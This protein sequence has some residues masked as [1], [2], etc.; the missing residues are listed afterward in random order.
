MKNPLN[1]RHFLRSSTAL[2][3]LPFLESLGF[4]RF[5]SAAV[6][7]AGVP[8]PKRLVFL[9]FGW[10]VTQDSWY[11]KIEQQ[12]CDYTLPAGLEPLAR[13]RADFSVVQGL[14]NKY[15]SN[16]HYGSTFWLTGANEFGQAGQSFHN[17]VS[18]DQVAGEHLGKEAR[19]DSLVLDC[20]AAAA[21]SGHGQ[22]LSLS[23]D[24]RGKPI[25]GPK[26]PVEAF[27][28]L[29]AKDTT[30]LAQ[31]KAML[32]Q[33]RSVLD[34]ALENARE[35][36][37]SLSK[38]DNAK[39]DEYFQGIRDIETRLSRDEKWLGVPRPEAPLKEPKS[40]LAGYEEIRLMYA[41]MAAAL[42]T[43]STR[44]LTY[45]QPV[46]TLLTSLDIRIDAHTMSHYLGKGPEY[47]EA[48]EKRDHAQSALLA[49]LLDQLKA[50]KEPDGSC[51]LDHTTVAFGSNIRT[52]HSLDNCPTLLAGR[53]AGIKMGANIV[54]PKDTPLCN[55]WLTLMQ[56]S[57]VPVERHGDSTGVI[58]QLLA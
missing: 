8:P 54:V 50:I 37:R 20:G 30:P 58:K 48:S 42:Q 56:G 10:G 44:V 9:G 24:I 12:G 29:F 14:L 31:Q 11:P 45:R 4:R 26:N 6:S 35:L 17:T 3:A 55:A 51:L 38:T 1:R 2:I 49:E 53:G 18:A 32:A 7:G 5:A 46:S 40:G 22:G 41:I 47:L 27:H 28:R 39:L 15:N 16:G 43:D 23:W 19:L 21:A 33:R 36:Q 13:H 52:S 34:N 25:S 57:G